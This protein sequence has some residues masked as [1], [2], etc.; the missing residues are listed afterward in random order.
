MVALAKIIDRLETEALLK[1]TDFVSLKSRKLIITARKS[2][3]H[4]AL[5]DVFLSTTNDNNNNNT[6]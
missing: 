1:L 5:F 4:V 6:C 3:A 2:V